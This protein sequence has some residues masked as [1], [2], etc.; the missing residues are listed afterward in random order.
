MSTKRKPST[1][2]RGSSTPIKTNNAAQTK[3]P[4]VEEKVLM[5][6]EEL[7]DIRRV[8]DQKVLA[9]VEELQGVRRVDEETGV[10]Y[11]ELADGWELELSPD[12]YRTGSL[13]LHLYPPR[14]GRSR[15]RFGP[16]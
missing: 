16:S 12:E 3:T 2:A 14:E 15:R 4:T 13:T 8:D 9:L 6:V 11:F 7:Q 5:L 10:I 1:K